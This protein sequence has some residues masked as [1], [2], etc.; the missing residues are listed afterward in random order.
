MQHKEW[1]N[2]RNRTRA[3]KEGGNY[4]TLQNNMD[5]VNLKRNTS[6]GMNCAVKAMRKA[7][8]TTASCDITARIPYHAPAMG[9]EEKEKRR[10]EKM[11]ERSEAGERGRIGVK[12]REGRR[13]RRQ[14][15]C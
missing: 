9:T 10:K 11:E 15:V 14:N 7:F 13:E 4:S 3:M 1:T 5:F 6:K 2:K 8:D 12:M